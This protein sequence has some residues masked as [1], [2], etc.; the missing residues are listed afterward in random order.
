MSNRRMVSRRFVN[1]LKPTVTRWYECIDTGDVFEVIAVDE[2]DEIVDVQNFD[3]E[4]AEMNMTT[5]RQLR[6]VRVAAPQ[7]SDHNLPY[8]SDHD[9]K[10]LNNVWNQWHQGS[11]AMH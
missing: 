7:W 3:G 8:E 2:H 11:R 9:V 5:W 10:M 6:L 4:V 1:R